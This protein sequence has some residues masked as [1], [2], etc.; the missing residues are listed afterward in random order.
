MPCS[1][2]YPN[3]S[4]TAP[5]KL[6]HRSTHCVFLGYSE[7]HKGYRCLN[8][9]TNHL[10]ISRHVVFDEA[11]FP[12]ATSPHRATNLQF[13][14]SETAPV[15]SPIGTCLPAG[16]TAPRAAT[17]EP[18]LTDAVGQATPLASGH[19]SLVSR[20]PDAPVAPLEPSTPMPRAASASTPSAPARP[21]RP[22]QPLG[23]RP[24]PRAIFTDPPAPDPQDA[25]VRPDRT[26]CK[27]YER[28]R[29]WVTSLAASASSSTV[30]PS[31]S[32]IV[33]L[34]VQQ[35]SADSAD[36]SRHSY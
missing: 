30:T 31:S 24:A 34:S 12:Y 16:S 29:R 15:V 21:A 26:F 2:H 1:V 14:L 27:V 5:H 9:S 4:A 18:S 19:P 3:M 36:C 20:G 10:V 23:D 32:A 25:L 6:A 22:H 17:L 7:H 11:V 13:L 33:A 8:L 28:H 35:L